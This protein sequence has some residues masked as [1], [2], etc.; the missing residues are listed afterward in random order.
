MG[1]TNPLGKMEVSLELVLAADTGK[2]EVIIKSGF[3]GEYLGTI[4]ESYR[5]DDG[6][7]V[8]VTTKEGAH[9]C[10]CMGTWHD[11]SC[12]CPPPGY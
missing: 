2:N 9:Q 8:L 6:R 10:K 12:I 11:G 5:D 7:V 1:A 4:G 3:S